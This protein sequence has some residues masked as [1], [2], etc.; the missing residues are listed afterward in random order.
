MLGTTLPTPLY[1]A[2]QQEIGFSSLVVTVV[3]AVYAFGVITS[4]LLFG[5]ASDQVGR[6][7]T[8]LVGL[9]LSAASA[10]CFLAASAL[11]EL[12]IGRVFS[13]LSAGLF[14]GTATATLV[15]LA[16]VE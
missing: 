13:G 15:D 9:G 4:L 10:V 1:P 11:G 5:S 7:P 16:G 14:T 2:Y 8:L 3:F 6:R 12:I